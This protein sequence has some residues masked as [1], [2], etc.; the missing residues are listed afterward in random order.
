MTTFQGYLAVRPSVTAA[1]HVGGARAQNARPETGPTNGSASGA[2][3]LEWQRDLVIFDK[4]PERRV[5]RRR[6]ENM[7]TAVLVLLYHDVT[8]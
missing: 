1:A 3:L 5:D 7:A 2:P 4:T 6:S 8:L